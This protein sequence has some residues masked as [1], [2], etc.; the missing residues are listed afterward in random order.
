MGGRKKKDGTVK[1]TSDHVG[2]NVFESHRM[3]IV[4][5][6]FRGAAHDMKNPLAVILQGA[7][8]LEYSK[9]LDDSAKKIIGMIGKAAS[10]I[11][12]TIE[13]ILGF[14]RPAAGQAQLTDIRT[15]IDESLALLGPQLSNSFVQVGKDFPQSIP[16]CMVNRS[17]IKHALVCVLMNAADAIPEDGIV[18]IEVR[19]VLYE[20]GKSSVAVMV[21]DNG[22]GILEEDLDR[23]F[24]PFFTT[25]K[26]QGRMGLGLAVARDII[27]RH[28]GHL[29]IEG[30]EG[31]GTSVLMVLP[32]E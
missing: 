6:L 13:N 30:K 9:T 16:E 3:T 2:S 21:T 29:S 32:A 7:E 10:R 20:S 19:Q 14:A 17:E 4:G 31:K 24:E 28:N 11:D 25:K 5:Q 22:C 26:D 8:F 18:S 27:E 23:V 15:L 12:A 1:Q